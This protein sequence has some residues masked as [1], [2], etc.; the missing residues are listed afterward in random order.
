M[1]DPILDRLQDLDA[2]P[3]SS[4]VK[5]ALWAFLLLTWA[6]LLISFGVSLFVPYFMIQVQET[7]RSAG[8]VIGI[9]NTLTTIGYLLSASVIGIWWGRLLAKKPD[10]TTWQILFFA[11][12]V[13]FI[14][15][16]VRILTTSFRF[17]IEH[18]NLVFAQIL[19]VAIFQSSVFASVVFAT[20]TFRRGK[21]YLPG[22]L[23]LVLVTLLTV[24]TLFIK[25]F[26]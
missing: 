7:Q 9:V 26:L 19:L 11:F 13:A 20:A 12:G 21:G 5:M 6:N 4:W 17:Q 23:A 15:L 10:L 18:I 1:Q 24:L 25:R 3:K 2:P 22:I 8:E 16:I 14:S